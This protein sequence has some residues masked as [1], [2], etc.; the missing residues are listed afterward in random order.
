MRVIEAP[1][2]LTY[3]LGNITLFLAGGIVGCPDWQSD[4]IQKL[5]L[6]DMKKPLNHLVILNPR[7]KNFPIEDPKAAKKQITWEFEALED[8]DIFSMWFCKSD[9][10]QP[11]CMY[12]LGRYLSKYENSAITSIASTPKEIVLGVEKGYK[13]EQDV[14]IQTKLVNET[15][16]IST[17]LDKHVKK[18]IKAYNEVCKYL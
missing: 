5:S 12:E 14:Y 1:E 10:V 7:R 18:I 4:V 17:T 15:I 2:E 11:I 3:D 16:K 8:A 9:S 13:R 6:H